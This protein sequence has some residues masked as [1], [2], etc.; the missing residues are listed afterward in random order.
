MNTLRDTQSALALW[1]MTLYQAGRLPLSG[2]APDR[3]VLIEAFAEDIDKLLKGLE[4]YL[5]QTKEQQPK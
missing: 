5:E 3:W 1:L 2:E 4:I